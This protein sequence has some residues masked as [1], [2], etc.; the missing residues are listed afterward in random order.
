MNSQLARIKADNS[1]YGVVRRAFWSMVVASAM[2]ALPTLATNAGAQSSSAAKTSAANAKAAKDAADKAAKEAAIQA[3]AAAEAQKQAQA[4][5][6]AAAAAAAKAEAEKQAAL[7]AQ[8]EKA[9]MEAAANQKAAEAAAKA[10]AAR[11]KAEADAAAAEAARKAQAEADALKKAAEGAKK[12]KEE[13]DAIAAA[14]AKRADEAN[15]NKNNTD[16]LGNSTDEETGKAA[17]AA[18]K[19]KEDSDNAAKEADKAAAAAARAEAAEQKYNNAQSDAEKQSAHDE[20]NAATNEAGNSENSAR[21]HEGNAHAKKNEADASSK[22]AQDN[23]RYMPG[24][25]PATSN[26]TATHREWMLCGG[27]YPGWSPTTPGAP[28]LCASVELNVASFGNVI[29]GQGPLAL[30]KLKV[31]NLSGLF[32]SYAGSVL[33]GIGLSNI[34]GGDPSRLSSVTGPCLPTEMDCAAQWSLLNGMHAKLPNGVGAVDYKFYTQG[35]IGGI[36]ST[37]ADHLNPA[38]PDG[39]GGYVTTP[40]NPNG[41]FTTGCFDLNS[42]V[43]FTFT[44]AEPIDISNAYV[45]LRA[46][47]GYQDGST[48]CITDDPHSETG[49]NICTPT[50]V[51]EPGTVVLMGSGM[52]ALFAVVHRRRR[53]EKA[54]EVDIIT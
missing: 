44:T 6:E 19:A 47:N 1:S 38:Q 2:I 26:F 13:A 41:L 39:N 24:L 31:R 50:T 17:A 29:D 11:L 5:K 22:K 46:Q 18:A 27:G 40:V 37:C 3:A 54:G 4:K 36:A 15:A 32:E 43:E 25:D 51:P 7:K 21:Q 14:N 12:Q 23:V 49:N 16:A 34:F 42:Y 30:L 8:A 9:A 10:E 53:R 45:A 28:G 48:A 35:L 33:T 20:L 52:A